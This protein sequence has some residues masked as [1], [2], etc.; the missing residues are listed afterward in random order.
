[1]FK[2]S[3]PV[4]LGIAMVGLIACTQGKTDHSASAPIDYAGLEQEIREVFDM[5]RQLF[6]NKDVGGLVDRFTED[7]VLKLPGRPAVV[8]HEALRSNYEGTVAL[9]NFELVLKPYVIK[10]SEKGDMAYALAEFAVSFNTAEGLFYDNGISQIVFVHLDGRW[11]IAAENLS[12]IAK[13][14]EKDS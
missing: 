1:M 7:G 4:L 12:P 9:E 2:K 14:I 13:P 11:K 8:G 5:S 3:I 6:Q 10:I